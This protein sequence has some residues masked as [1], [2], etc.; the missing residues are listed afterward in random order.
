MAIFKHIFHQNLSREI[1]TS[2]FWWAIYLLELFESCLVKRKLSSGPFYKK[3]CVFLLSQGMYR[4]F[5]DKGSLVLV[6]VL[7]R[8]K[9]MTS[10]HEG[11]FFFHILL[12]NKI[13]NSVCKWAGDHMRGSFW[14][15]KKNLNIISVLLLRILPCCW[16]SPSMENH[17]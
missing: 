11:S 8:E 12:L 1:S 15:K 5:L 7:E 16:S 6:A 2:Y 3:H 17:V 4:L 9:S 10:W 14:G 13:P